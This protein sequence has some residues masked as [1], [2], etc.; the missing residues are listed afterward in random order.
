MGYLRPE[1][2]DK[3]NYAAQPCG[4]ATSQRD[5]SLRASDRRSLGRNGTTVKPVTAHTWAWPPPM[6]WHSP[7]T[8]ALDARRRS[9]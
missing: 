3:C 2:V 6:R 8:P 5:R 7:A 9:R 4:P 1:G